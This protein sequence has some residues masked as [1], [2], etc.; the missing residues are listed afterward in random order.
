MLAIVWPDEAHHVTRE[1]VCEPVRKHNG[2]QEQREPRAGVNPVK[3]GVADICSMTSCTTSLAAL[4]VSNVGRDPQ[5]AF[6]WL[7]NARADEAMTAQVSPM[8]DVT[9]ERTVLI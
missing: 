6:D 2:M 1:V 9:F 8:M 3:R 5:C 7:S 4:T